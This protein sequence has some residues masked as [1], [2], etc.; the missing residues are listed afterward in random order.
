MINALCDFF[1]RECRHACS[2]EYLWTDNR[3]RDVRGP[4]SS[5]VA[6]RC[7]MC[8]TRGE[9]IAMYQPSRAEELGCLMQLEILAWGLTFAIFLFLISQF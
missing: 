7:S 3:W 6:E 9:Y 5:Y 2:R 8:R 1:Y 4:N